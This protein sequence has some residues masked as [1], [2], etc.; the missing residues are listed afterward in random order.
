MSIL[1]L[2]LVTC[3]VLFPYKSSNIVFFCGSRLL[4]CMVCCEQTVQVDLK[5]NGYL[6][7]INVLLDTPSAEVPATEAEQVSRF[8]SVFSHALTRLPGQAFTC[9]CSLSCSPS[10]SV[11]LLFLVG[12]MNECWKQVKERIKEH[13]NLNW[14]YDV[15]LTWDEI[16]AV[17]WN[18]SFESFPRQILHSCFD[19]YNHK[20]RLTLR[21]TRIWVA[22]TNS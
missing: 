21:S 13:F 10:P 3:C 16:S 9:S 2:K 17:C 12:F 1:Q 20:K 14:H 22:K 11:S 15:W 8:A 6:Y 7:F 18:E 4:F 5:D 19:C